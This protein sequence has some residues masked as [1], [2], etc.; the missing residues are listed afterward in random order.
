MKH[1]DRLKAAG[2][3]NPLNR[4]PQ[5][6]SQAGDSNMYTYIKRVKTRNKIYRYLVIECYLG[7]GKRKK[8][9]HIP[10][11]KILEDYIDEEL[12]SEIANWCGGWD[13]NPRRP[14][15]TGLEPAPFGQARAPPH[16]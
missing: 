4:I 2:E 10:I 7:N 9:L 1:N 15:P 6:R 12:R 3:N 8:L 14:T 11:K 5:Q 16:P 13:S